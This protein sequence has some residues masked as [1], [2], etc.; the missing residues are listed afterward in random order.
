MKHVRGVG[1]FEDMIDL[2]G[3]LRFR[4]MRLRD[5]DRMPFLL[6][7]CA[8]TLEVVMLNLADPCGEKISLGSM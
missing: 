1:L 4:C 8:E 3:G 2:F 7:A 6:A 5:V